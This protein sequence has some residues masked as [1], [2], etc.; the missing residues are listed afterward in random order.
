MGF[1]RS[2]CQSREPGSFDRCLVA[3]SLPTAELGDSLISIHFCVPVVTHTQE[4]RRVEL[5]RWQVSRHLVYTTDTS[6]HTPVS[7][8]MICMP[9]SSPA[10]RRMPSSCWGFVTA[11]TSLWLLQ[12]SAS[13]R[14]PVASYQQVAHLNTFTR[15]CSDAR[16]AS[17]THL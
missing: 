5:E 17:K 1:G 4:G 11:L 9:I 8:S 3:L 14:M 16:Q 7:H 12:Y 2:D 15:A 6:V 10:L 13:D